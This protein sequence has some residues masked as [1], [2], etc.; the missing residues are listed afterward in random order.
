MAPPRSW[1]GD[2]GIMLNGILKKCGIW[3]ESGSS[4][5]D[6]NGTTNLMTW[7]EF[8]SKQ[9]YLKLPNNKSVHCSKL[10]TVPLIK[11]CKNGTNKMNVANRR[12]F[13]PCMICG[14]QRGIRAD[15]CQINSVLCFQYHSIWV[16]YLY[17]FKYHGRFVL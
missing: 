1:D 13:S 16:L 15:F 6:G 7:M 12:Q 14:G 11:I 10:V 9:C 17:I 2:Y 5:L 3:M 4:H 8:L